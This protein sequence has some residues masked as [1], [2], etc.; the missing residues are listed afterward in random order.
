MSPSRRQFLV[1]SSLAA[2][3]RADIKAGKWRDV[4]VKVTDRLKGF[5]DHGPLIGRVLSAAYDELA[6]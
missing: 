4:T 5:P 3:A 2:F 1:S 6:G